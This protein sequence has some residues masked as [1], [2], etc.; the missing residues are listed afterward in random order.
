MT[1]YF[2]FNKIKYPKSYSLK[3]LGC[4]DFMDNG[5]AF[6]IEYFV[7]DSLVI[8]CVARVSGCVSV[9]IVKTKNT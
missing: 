4:C 5:A 2:L 6:S 9:M 1:I 7:F 3:T 8:L